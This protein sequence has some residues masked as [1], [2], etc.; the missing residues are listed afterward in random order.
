MK[1][2]SR[3]GLSC[4]HTRAADFPSPQRG[5]QPRAHVFGDCPSPSARRTPPTRSLS[6]SKPCEIPVTLTHC[7]RV[8]CGVCTRPLT[9]MPP[10]LGTPFCWTG[11][12][13]TWLCRGFSCRR[14][15]TVAL[16]PF[17]CQ[18]ADGPKFRAFTALR[19]LYTFLII[20]N[21]SALLRS[22]GCLYHHLP[23]DSPSSSC[24]MPSGAWTAPELLYQISPL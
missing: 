7:K 24:C 13:A 3:S 9:A 2:A 18:G 17:N 1:S 15:V 12:R 10:T 8:S 14:P 22:D 11:A 21:G 6:T 5:L 19:F 4:R 20:R 23:S 16:V